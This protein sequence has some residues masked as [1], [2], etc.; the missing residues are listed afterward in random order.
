MHLNASYCP[1]PEDSCSLC[2]DVSPAM[3]PG[4]EVSWLAEAFQGIV[5]SCGLVEAYAA[6]LST[7]DDTCS[8]L[9]AVSSYCGCAPIENHCVYC[10]GENLQDDCKD[11][12]F[13]KLMVITGTCELYFLT[14]YQLSKE[15]ELCD[16]LQDGNVQLRLQ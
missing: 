12:E 16:L 13:P 6:S 10:P 15:D 5:P 4:K 14:Q 7:K 8:S 2:P 3:E 11:V 1:A 9:Q